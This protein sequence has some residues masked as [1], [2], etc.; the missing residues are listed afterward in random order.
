MF[1]GSSIAGWKGIEA[2]DLDPDAGRQHRRPRS[3]HRRAD[4][5]P[6]LRHRAEHHAGYER[7]PRNIAK[8]RGT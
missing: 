7:D 2:S 6:G 5:D 4:P 3:V 8:R 1:D